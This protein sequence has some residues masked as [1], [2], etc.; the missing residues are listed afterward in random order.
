MREKSKLRLTKFHLTLDSDSDISQP[1]AGKK[2][3]LS[4]CSKQFIPDSSSEDSQPEVW[5][6]TGKPS[7]DA[8]EYT[9]EEPDISEEEYQS[10]AEEKR[11][12]DLLTGWGEQLLF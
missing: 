1:K 4:H 3:L 9:P 11:S 7:F 2:I 6:I 10:G 12:E 8:L 5:N